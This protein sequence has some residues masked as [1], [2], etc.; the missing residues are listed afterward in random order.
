M[1]DEAGSRKGPSARRMP[2]IS[3][4][5]AS[6][7]RRWTAR[8][9][10]SSWSR[11]GEPEEERSA[12]GL[13]ARVD[14][15]GLLRPGERRLLLSSSSSSSSG[16]LLL[17]LLFPGILLLLLCDDG[18]GGGGGDDERLPCGGV[19]VSSLLLLGSNGE[20]EPRR[21]AGLLLLGRFRARKPLLF[22]P[23]VLLRSMVSYSFFFQPFW[24]S[25]GGQIMTLE[26]A[27]WEKR[28]C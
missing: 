26:L 3:S 15:P 27:A 8:S 17:L 19:G 9:L 13:G 5:Q 22:C 18:G 4:S 24:T 10:V 2:W 21:D 12:A 6:L 16:L 23:L 25:P 20:D 28:A 11:R 7:R 14:P 1:G